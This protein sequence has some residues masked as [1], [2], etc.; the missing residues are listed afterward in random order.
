VYEDCERCPHCGDYITPRSRTIFAPG[1]RWLKFV[2]A[3]TIVL[4]LLAVIM[5]I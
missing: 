2:V 5:S 4:L 1:G 3:L